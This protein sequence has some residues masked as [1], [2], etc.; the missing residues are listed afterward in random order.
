M[1]TKSVPHLFAGRYRRGDALGDSTQ[2]NAKVYK[3]FDTDTEDTPVAVK[4]LNLNHPYPAEKEMAWS[5]FMK[6][7]KALEDIE[8]DAIVKML[9][10][11][12]DREEAGIVLELIEGGKTVEDLIKEA[13]GNPP[14]RRSLRW[15]VIQLLRIL[16]AI[17][18]THQ[19][20]II[21][22]DIKLRNILHDRTD[23]SLKLV[24][25]GIAKIAHQFDLRTVAGSGSKP[26]S[27]PEQLRRIAT[28]RQA[29]LYAFGLVVASLLTDQIPDEG[30]LQKD[31]P[32]FLEP[33]RGR[34]AKPQI[35]DQILDTLT[36]LLSEDP[37]ERPD[38]WEIKRALDALLG[39]LRDRPEA[40]LSINHRRREE[41]ERNLHM[42][43]DEFLIDLNDG[44]RAR[45]ERREDDDRLFTVWLYGRTVWLK[46][47]Q[48]RDDGDRLIVVKSGRIN[49]P[50]EQRRRDEA[51]SIPH[52]IKFNAGKDAKDLLD[53]VYEYFR[54]GID[55][56]TN[57]QRRKEYLRL[58][59]EYLQ[60]RENHLQD[61][62]LEC[63]WLGGTRQGGAAIKGAAGAYALTQNDRIR[64]RVR[65]VS[66]EAPSGQHLSVNEDLTSILENFAD[67]FERSSN[68]L[69]K[70]RSIGSIVGIDIVKQD[71]TVE[72]DSDA[73]IRFPVLSDEDLSTSLF[74]AHNSGL[75]HSLRRERDAVEAFIL[76]QTDNARLPELLLRPRQNRLRPVESRALLQSNLK[77]P[78]QMQQMI[79]R[80]LSARD[81]YA[82]QGP[83]GTGKTTTITEVIL[84]I[85][86]DTPSARIL[87]TSQ[88]N[89][90]VDNAMQKISDV[91]SKAGR[92]VRLLREVSELRTRT[93]PLGFAETFTTWV[94]TTAD[95]S[96]TGMDAGIQAIK[97]LAPERQASIRETLAEW[98]NQL[99]I[100]ED[101]KEDFLINIQVFGVTCLRLPTLFRRYPHLQDMSFDWI[102]VD[103]AA[104]AHASEL[105]VALNHGQ[106]II[107]VG[108]QKQL[109]PHLSREDE[110]AL[111]DKGFS[112]QES[113]TSLFETLF[114]E[115]PD[116]N[117]SRLDLQFRMHESIAR[118]ISNLYYADD[119]VELATDTSASD[120]DIPV[121]SFER[122]ERV[123]WIDVRGC[124]D[125]IEGSTSQFNREEAVS[126]KKILDI[127]KGNMA[128]DPKGGNITVAIITPY[129][130]QRQFLQKEIVPEA[131]E[132]WRRLDIKIDTIDAFQGKE[133]DIVILSFVTTEG[134]RNK[135]VGDPHRLNVAFSRAKRLLLI[136]G[137][138]ERAK[139]DPELARVI[140]AIP[141]ANQIPWGKR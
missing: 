133:S 85:L 80:A 130:L 38:R 35:Y 14:V 60:I 44:I 73:R 115:L 46:A 57:Q 75:E 59:E 82:I 11:F 125:T 132:R 118:M 31:M 97:H 26:F 28:R 136:I 42:N 67:T 84:Q 10:K 2:Y 48:D 126:I 134:G 127:F 116:S 21:H 72:I 18:V 64:L 6:E 120:M 56:S 77:P 13:R 70:G 51:S 91:A 96:R 19:R 111:V 23:D 62:W 1:T 124:Q 74:L 129:D 135:F 4:I 63:S 139:L 140:D 86:S 81:I 34:I 8:H 141:I 137:H 105:L 79:E 32:A 113:R 24:D 45:C 76:G 90:A 112:P 50:R 3:A 103:E 65:A 17:E 54:A 33:L 61:I 123:F 102:I 58:A 40:N 106:R 49:H 104:R 83:P 36:K 131:K 99:P 30:F 5:M 78:E 37:E 114:T 69:Y 87:L 98:Q 107:L 121:K 7:V 89:D 55:A 92:P 39:N 15:K 27:P 16:E 68:L 9:D 110:Q 119:G 47:H 20:Q 29:D 43:S 109:P 122:S 94:S 25:F 53:L 22:R 100:A 95:A 66:L 88:N 117:R 108:D 52:Q 71:I 128:S 101:V 138:K 93:N 12:Y 41:I